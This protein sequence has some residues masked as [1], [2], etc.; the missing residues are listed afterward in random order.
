MATKFSNEL[1]QQALAGAIN[2]HD[3]LA[4]S[5]IELQSA[6]D[7]LLE[8]ITA[9]EAELARLAERPFST[10]STS[11]AEI[12]A[13]T[14]EQ[15]NTRAEL[16]RQLEA[17]KRK[18]RLVDDSR[19]KTSTDL[20]LASTAVKEGRCTVAANLERRSRK[21]IAGAVRALNAVRAVWDEALEGGF[22]FADWARDLLLEHRPTEAQYASAREMLRIEDE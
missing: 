20:H 7:N 8:G 12:E 5:Q 22:D 6:R 11:L 2:E 9:L 19:T 21:D 14:S 17:E 1:T 13:Q 15:E 10:S 16:Q 3:R 4:R 18:L